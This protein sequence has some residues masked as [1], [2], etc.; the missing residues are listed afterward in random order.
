MSSLIEIGI[1][2]C[3]KLL[4]KVIWASCVHNTWAWNKMVVVQV[5]GMLHSS[6]EGDLKVIFSI[7]NAIASKHVHTGKRKIWFLLLFDPL[8]FV[9]YNISK[10]S[11]FRSIQCTSDWKLVVVVVGLSHTSGNIFGIKFV[12]E[13]VM[14][15]D[16]QCVTLFGSS[17]ESNRQRGSYCTQ[18]TLTAN[19]PYW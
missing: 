16:Y 6:A 17:S 14:G 3:Q 15:K 7:L 2:Q 10:L 12:C 4:M 1:K 8:T 5:V 13:L 19:W 9:G 18:I 11:Y